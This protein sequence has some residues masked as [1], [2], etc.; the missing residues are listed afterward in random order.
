MHDHTVLQPRAALGTRGRHPVITGCVASFQVVHRLALSLRIA[1]SPPA[2][3]PLIMA[4]DGP[5]PQALK[6]WEDAFHYP[7]PTVRRVE[8]E[9]RRDIASNKEKLR[10]LVGYVTVTSKFTPVRANRIL[11]I[12]HEV[13]RACWHCRDDRVDEL[14][15]GGCRFD[16]GRYRTKMQ[17]APD[18][19][20]VHALQPDKGGFA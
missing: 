8:Q 12:Q 1:G 13:P 18:G 4:S 14:R 19:E 20:D 15:N 10:A 2:P 17:P 6:S 16:T 7:I 5:D 3:F 9:L 11:C